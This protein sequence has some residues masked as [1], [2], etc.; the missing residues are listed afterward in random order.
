MQK[1]EHRVFLHMLRHLFEQGKRGA[2]FNM[3]SALIVYGYFEMTSATLPGL[4]LWLAGTVLTGLAR[5]ML[6]AYA[7]HCRQNAKLILCHKVMFGIVFL[8]G[9]MWG[10]LYWVYFNEMSMFQQLF[11]AL[12]LTS[13]T[14]LSIS[15]FSASRPCYLAFVIPTLTPMIIMTLT[16][17][18]EEYVYFGTAIFL[19]A[20]FIMYVFTQH[21]NALLENPRLEISRESLL[22]RLQGMNEKLLR[23]SRTDALTH[24]ANRHHFNEQLHADWMRCKRAETPIGLI[25]I[26]IDYF[27]QYNDHY[28]HLGG[29]QCLQHI[30]RI[31]RRIVR[32]TTDLAARFGGDEIAIILFNTGLEHAKSIGLEIQQELYLEQL[33]HSGSPWGLITLS[34]GVVAGIPA[35]D[36]AEDH[37]L[38]QA[39]AALYRAKRQGRNTLEAAPLFHCAEAVRQL[40]EPV[41]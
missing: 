21:R 11:A 40:P 33:P 28:G 14:T 34:I 24:L 17:T 19:Y 31:L 9:C 26:D 10:S 1:T 13:G 39:D 2:L 18:H 7:G 37:L 38:A 23:T 12:M 3:L 35:G 27:K 20:L 8:N 16:A 22:K 41:L 29:D 36:A 15:A 25:L 30:A 5:F 32:R 4:H 6:S